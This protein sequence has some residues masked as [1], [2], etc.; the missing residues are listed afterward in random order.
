MS[1]P[2]FE[3][4]AAPAIDKTNPTIPPA[5]VPRPGITEPI[6]APVAAP[7][8]APIPPKSDSL[9]YLTASF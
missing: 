5:A 6:A 8:T 1:L 2:I 7:V 3:P 9:L 4:K